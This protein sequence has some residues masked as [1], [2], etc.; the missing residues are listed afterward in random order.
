MRHALL[1]PWL[2]GGIVLGAC[3]W[4]GSGSGPDD[5]GDV[6]RGT[7]LGVRLEL[8]LNARYAYLGE[9]VRL[10]TVTE[11]QYGDGSV[12]VP[13]HALFT[14]SVSSR[15]TSSIF[16]T[17]DRLTFDGMTQRVRARIVGT[18]TGFSGRLHTGDEV[19]VRLDS[20][21]LSRMALLRSRDALH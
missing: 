6:P 11:L 2:L 18:E 1:V 4:L 20:S 13:R 15:T 7:M 3:S 12:A 5:A 14:G 19:V 9:P 17:I 16:I 10:R 8:P 21:V